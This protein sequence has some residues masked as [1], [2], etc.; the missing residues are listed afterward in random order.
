MVGVGR[1]RSIRLRPSYL[2]AKIFFDNREKPLNS[3]RV[4]QT[5]PLNGFRI[6]Q[7]GLGARLLV[8]GRP[9]L[10]TRPA[11]GHG[12]QRS[13]TRR[14]PASQVMME[15]A[16]IREPNTHEKVDQLPLRRAGR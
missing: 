2:I 3:L 1:R 16:S 8:V 13:D 12:S 7:L 5:K 15:L 4:F 11:A 6:G 14:Q 9:R 10:L